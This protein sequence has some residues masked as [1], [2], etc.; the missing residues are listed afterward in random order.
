MS[1]VN[2]TLLIVLFAMLFAII[3][4]AIRVSRLLAHPAIKD[5]SPPKASARKGIFYAFTL[6]M[7][8]WKKE[9]AR[10]HPLVYLRGVLFHIGIFTF[11]VLL[12]V[13][14]FVNISHL[15][16]RLA[17]SPFLGL[18]LIAGVT[19]LVARFTDRNLRAISRPDDY[20]SLILVTLALLSGLTMV[21]NITSRPVFWGFVSVLCLYL[22]WSKIPHVAYFFFSRTVF[23]VM[24]GRRGVLP[25]AKTELRN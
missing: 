3:G 18:G 4:L 9:S 22:P 25:A 24:F 8:P 16:G 10:L 12:L 21:L 14:L 6:G 23:G 7:L 17:F 15:S 1:A 20:I 19:A 2:I 11:V 5:P 13:S